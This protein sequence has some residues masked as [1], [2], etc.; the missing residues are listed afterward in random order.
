MRRIVG[1]LVALTLLAGLQVGLLGTVHAEEAIRVTVNGQM[2]SFDQPPIIEQDRVLVPVRAIFEALSARVDWDAENRRVTAQKGS[3]VVTLTIGRYV[4]Y[5]NGN[6]VPLD[7]APKIVGDRTLVPIRA[8]SESFGAQ[9]TWTASERLV[10]VTT[11]GG[12]ATPETPQTGHAYERRV[13]ELVNEERAKQGLSPLTWHEGLANV[14]R[15]HSQDMNDRRFFSHDNPDGQSP[16]DRIKAAGIAYT[17]AAE[18]VAAG[19]KTPEEV[20]QGW[21]NSAGHRA[22]ILNPNLTALGVGYYAGDGPYTHY[23]TQCFI[24]Q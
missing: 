6:A 20:M 16:F 1:M 2:L 13:L 11:A 24:T 5:R 19:Q 17:R 9:V 3:D 18:N 22:N 8:V 21:M 14:A 23:W 15:A 4:M 12:A 7:A 10:T